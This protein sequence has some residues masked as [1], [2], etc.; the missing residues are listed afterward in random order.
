ML[1]RFATFHLSYKPAHIHLGDFGGDWGVYWGTCKAGPN[2][3][4]NARA[5]PK[6]AVDCYLWSAEGFP[7]HA[8]IGPGGGGVYCLKRGRSAQ[9]PLQ[10]FA[11]PLLCTSAI[12]N[13]VAPIPLRPHRAPCSP[14]RPH[15][16][17]VSRRLAPSS[18]PTAAGGGV[19]PTPTDS[20]VDDLSFPFQLK[21][22][23]Q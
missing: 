9:G 23:S 8:K 13:T 16:H 21:F 22:T 3:G 10:P 14:A 5:Q 6:K 19:S 4:Q 2:S 18:A 17:H 20:A 11:P 1:A 15:N 12:K 7:S